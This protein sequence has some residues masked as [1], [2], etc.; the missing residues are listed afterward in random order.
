MRRLC[1]R[2]AAAI[3]V[4]ALPSFLPTYEELVATS[5][6]ELT[7]TDVFSELAEEALA[8][9]SASRGER[10]ERSLENL[11]AAVEQVAADARVDAEAVVGDAFLGTL[12]RRGI[13]LADAYLGEKTAA[14]ASSRQLGEVGPD[15]GDDHE[16]VS[17]ATPPRLRPRPRRYSGRAPRRRRR[18]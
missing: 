13:R 3:L 10:E 8:L 18:L 7:S 16:P 9:L 12:G 4:A 2:R 15:P 14:L 17:R 5:G 1:E 6:E 11:F